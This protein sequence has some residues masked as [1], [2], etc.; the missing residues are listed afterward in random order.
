MRS[1]LAVARAYLQARRQQVAAR[2]RLDGPLSDAAAMAEDFARYNALGL[3]LAEAR[4]AAEEEMRTGR[5]PHEGYSFGLSTGTMGEPGVFLTTQRERDRW[6]GTILA[7]FLDLR[8]VLTLRAALLLKHN[9][10]L[11]AVSDRVAFFDLR[12]PVEE[13]AAKVCARSPNVIIGPPSALEALA[14][15][16][17]FERRPVRPHTLLCG[18][19]PLFPQD[20]ARLE[21]AYGIAP[22]NLY[23]ARE[24][25]LAAG[26]RR[27][28][29]HWNEDLIAVEEMGFAGRPDRFVPVI[30][31]L[32]RESQVFRRYRMD[33]VV[34]RGQCDCGSPFG[35]VR[36]VEGRLND[37]LL[38]PDAANGYTPLFPME[39]NEAMPCLDDYVLRQHD[40]E[41]FTLA[42][43]RAPRGEGLNAIREALRH[44]RRLELVPL[45]P[46]A[47]GEKRR[48]FRRLFDGGNAIIL[49]T[50]LTAPQ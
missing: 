20:R 34:V 23:Q 47:P 39:L 1:K 7:R 11:Y 36:T 37:V 45:R 48:R 3:M 18:A 21:A 26:C 25:F 10:R 14:R 42:T 50:M 15:T 27:G 38:R 31:D 9:N 13:W 29:L 46:D 16:A 8:Q 40:P 5:S 43:P 33:D 24:G 17:A 30:T 35:S 49:R 12:R 4:A 44:P 19:E 6:L 2:P 41:H 28:A 22:R 32:A